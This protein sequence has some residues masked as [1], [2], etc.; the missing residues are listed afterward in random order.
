MED[1]C[2]RALKKKIV[3]DFHFNSFLLLGTILFLCAVLTT[4][5]PTSPCRTLHSHIWEKSDRQAER[6]E[7]RLYTSKVHAISLIHLFSKTTT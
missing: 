2:S 5:T 6:Q 7:R 4:E 1:Y 3:Q